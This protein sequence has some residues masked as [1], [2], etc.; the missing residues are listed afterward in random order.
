[1]MKAFTSDSIIHQMTFS[2]HRKGVKTTTLTYS[3]SKTDQRRECSVQKV[4]E[5]AR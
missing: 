5:N 1:M 4:S 3:V 2:K